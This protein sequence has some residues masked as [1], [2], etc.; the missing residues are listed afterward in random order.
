M[1]PLARLGRYENR[2]AK[3]RRAGSEPKEAGGASGPS[4]TGSVRASVPV[5]GG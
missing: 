1:S 3:A 2:V 5:T 4:N